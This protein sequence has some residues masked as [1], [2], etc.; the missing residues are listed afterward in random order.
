MK[1]WFGTM[2]R[3]RV[4]VVVG[5]VGCFSAASVVHADAFEGYRL[6]RSINLLPG[7]AVFDALDDGRLVVVS[8]A[9]VHI[10]TGVRTGQFAL[11]GELP[12][13]DMAGFGAAFLRVS[14]D[15]QRMAVGNN[16]GALGGNEQVGVF[17]VNSL[18]G[19]WFD[20]AH[21]DAA[22]VDDTFLA[23]TAGDFVNP[24]AVTILDTTSADPQNPDVVTVIDGIGGASGG[25][26]FDA[27]G[28]LYTGNG[29][30]FSGP[31]VTGTVKAFANSAWTNAITSEVPL[32]FE[33]EGQ[34][35][36]VAL[37]AWP[38]GFDHEGNLFIGGG[39]FS[40]MDRYDYVGIAR[41]SAVAAAFG[42]GPPV[43]SADPD[44]FLR[45]DPDKSNNFNFFGA[46]F[47]PVTTELYVRDSGTDFAF[48]Y[49]DITGIPTVS[50]W[51]MVSL[52]LATMIAATLAI[53]RRSAGGT[54]VDRPRGAILGM[55]TV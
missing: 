12:D 15:G 33:S 11:H 40:D 19:E 7:S 22:W 21:F 16:G 47:N 49:L 30:E 17:D 55:E 13:A 9:D 14:P 44:Q 6:V 31:S 2:R 53:S 1:K 8:G 46:G 26:A 34:L 51:G 28:N 18:A 35:I 27:E 38:L 42:G 45:L 5:G 36:I 43:S 32:N 23:L 52:A 41:G 54:P 25:I 50:T 39:D 4:A 37:S 48:A 10:E 24:S 20:V 3:L 29:F